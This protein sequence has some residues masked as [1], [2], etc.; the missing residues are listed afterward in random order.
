MLSRMSAAP[1]DGAVPVSSGDLDA[2]RAVAFVRTWLR[3]TEA[4]GQALTPEDVIGTVVGEGV[5]AMGAD[6]GSV[7]L[8]A[9]DGAHLDI[10]G[11]VGYPPERVDAWRRLPLSRNTPVTAAFL[12]GRPH[13]IET[14]AQAVADYPALRG[15]LENASGSLATLPLVVR[16]ETLGVLA[17]TFHHTRPF[18]PTDRAFLGSLA[19]TCAQ[20]LQRSAALAEAHLL[21]DRLQ[22]LAEASAILTRSLDLDAT[23][24][25]VARLTIPGIAEWC[26]IYLPDEAGQLEPV[27]IT[28]EE[29]AMVALLREFIHRH[30]P[31]TDA[32]AGRVFATGQP[33]FI[34]V[35]TDATY[36]A[37]PLP[38][39]EKDEIRRLALRSVVTVPMVAGGRTVGVLG[40]GRTRA[41]RA[42]TADDF[43][44][45][46]QI[47]SRAGKAVENA[48]L[49]RE[50]RREL[51]ERERAQRA[52]D[53]MNAHLEERVQART[54][55]LQQ[56]NDE[57]Q[58]FAHSASHDLRTPIRHLISFTD[59]LS[60]HLPAG[61]ERAEAVTRQIQD[62]ARRLSDTVD[63]LLTLSRASQQPLQRREV[64]LEGLIHRVI[65]QLREDG[66]GRGASWRVAALPSVQADPELLV[67]ALHN[68]LGNAVKYSA[69]Q[70]APVIEVWAQRREGSTFVSVRDNGV[71]FDPRFAGKLFQPFQRLHHVSEFP[72]TG[73][74]LTNVRRIVA[75]HGGQVWADG[76]PGL[77]ATFTF[78]LPDGEP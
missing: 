39:A 73:L 26:V 35:I 27:T 14:V 25:A 63:G 19:S 54:V 22:F 44:F 31:R 7:F 56:L 45:A 16:D 15:V 52:L 74:G 69:G 24:D 55:E 2:D 8:P 36:D 33:D 32:G 49:H 59:L 6:A 18:D 20:A 29:P 4:L 76:S 9:G 13:F 51:Q 46:Q 65:E 30:P 72:G 50:L 66:P 78:S 60:R 77:G 1:Q 70:P 11:T 47:A 17:L 57:L 28:H 23:L 62:S 21:N 68:L 42:Y 53:A 64:E 12:H 10:R 40:L 3:I 67:L 58:A 71:G 41:D 38:A 5:Q 75:R 43:E 61:N 48:R 37:A 34:P